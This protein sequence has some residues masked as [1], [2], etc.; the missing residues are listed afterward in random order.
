MTDTTNRRGRPRL[1][2]HGRPAVAIHLKVAAEDFD[3]GSK[4]ARA[5]R[6]SIQDVI[7]RGLR[8]ELG[9]IKP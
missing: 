3:R 1:D 9:V 7:R 2:P 4:I 8:R 6:E 5:G